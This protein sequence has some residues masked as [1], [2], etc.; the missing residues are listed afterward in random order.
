MR[1][2]SL[3]FLRTLVNTP[4]PT[5]H[6][7]PGQRVWLDYVKPLADETSSDAYGNCVAT[8]TRAVPHA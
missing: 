5:S 4:S 1:E 6:E 7:A 8:S 3:N 2:P